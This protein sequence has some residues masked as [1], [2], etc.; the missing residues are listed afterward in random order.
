MTLWESI[1][2]TLVLFVVCLPYPP[3]GAKSNLADWSPTRPSNLL[4]LLATS[5][6]IWYCSLHHFVNYRSSGIFAGCCWLIVLARLLRSEA[7]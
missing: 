7:T 2:I 1:F 5:Y 3:K 6:S 4:L